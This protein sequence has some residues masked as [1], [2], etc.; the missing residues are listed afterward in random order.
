MITSDY[1]RWLLTTFHAYKT[2]YG[3]GLTHTP[4][5][6]TTLHTYNASIHTGGDIKT[7]PT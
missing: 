4:P 2:V 1:N 5:P 3:V 7:R 6:H